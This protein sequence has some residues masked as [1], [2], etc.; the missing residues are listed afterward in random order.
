MLLY[1]LLPAAEVRL[2]LD[3][4]ARDRLRDRVAALLAPYDEALE[5]DEHDELCA[6]TLDPQV[7]LMD[8]LISLGTA[9]QV[10]AGPLHGLRRWRSQLAAGPRLRARTGCP[11]CSDRGSYRSV[12]NPQGRWASWRLSG[13]QEPTAKELFYL[14]MYS[15]LSHGALMTPD[16]RWHEPH[17]VTAT[18]LRPVY[19]DHELAVVDY[20][21]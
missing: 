9:L 3:D 20:Q 15:G 1:V 14:L 18:L 10:S 13:R 16:G 5:V 6:C 19:H 12:R 4:L 17:E 8:R 21:I 11:T 7:A 2:P